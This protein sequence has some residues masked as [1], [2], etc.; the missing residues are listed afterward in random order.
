MSDG[1]TTFR[2]QG[3]EIVI[4]GAGI[5]YSEELGPLG[6]VD[7]A[8]T[9][10]MVWLALAQVLLDQT[11]QESYQDQTPFSFLPHV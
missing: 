5:A 11:P 7:D 9:D 2:V 8:T 4:D 1:K 6:H 3:F 10:G